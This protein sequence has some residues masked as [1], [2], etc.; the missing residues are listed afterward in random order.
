[1]KD[2][3]QR[4]K[5]VRS[6]SKVFFCKVCNNKIVAEENGRNKTYMTKHLRMITDKGK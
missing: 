2:E 5:Q 6:E 1:M 4:K 3:R